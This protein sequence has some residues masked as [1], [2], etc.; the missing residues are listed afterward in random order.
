MMLTPLYR[1]LC[2]AALCRDGVLEPSVSAT[3]EFRDG[4][5]DLLEADDGVALALQALAF[6]DAATGAVLGREVVQALAKQFRIEHLQTR[7]DV[8]CSSGHSVISDDL[9]DALH[10]AARVLA[11]QRSI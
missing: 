10:D 1:A 6:A 4:S 7:Y 8:E 9:I 11:S 3:G 2:E 5:G